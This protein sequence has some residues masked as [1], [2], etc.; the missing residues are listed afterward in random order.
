MGYMK[1]VMEGTFNII[2]LLIEKYESIDL[3]YGLEAAR[4]DGHLDSII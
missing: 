4:Y 3:N 2:N 1:L